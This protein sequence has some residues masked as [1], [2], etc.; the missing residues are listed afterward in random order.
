LAK[1]RTSC[2]ERLSKLDHSYLGGRISQKKY[3]SRRKRLQKNCRTGKELEIVGWAGKGRVVV[4]ASSLSKK[5][6][7]EAKRA[8]HL[9]RTNFPEW[10]KKYHIETP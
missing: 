3:E 1:E 6:V 8:E 4:A 7:A 10:K 9:R 2:L 5:T